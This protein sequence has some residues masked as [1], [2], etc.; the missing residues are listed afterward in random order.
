MATTPSVPGPS[1]ARGTRIR[2]PATLA[3]LAAWDVDR[4]KVFGR[5]VSQVMTS[6][7]YASARR[8]FWIVDDGSAHCGQP[9]AGGL[10]SRWPTLR[11]LH[12]ST[13]ASWLNQ[14]EI[15]FSV[16]Q[17][18]VL[19]SKHFHS[20]DELEARLT[21]FGTTTSR[22]PHHSN[23]SSPSPTLEDLLDCLIAHNNAQLTPAI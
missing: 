23:G 3:Y 12:L 17:R 5:L 20:V 7:P 21:N 10:Q 15:Y 1:G 8:V 2:S 22:S 4:A 13:D 14:V 18:K 19:A 16:A 6:A 9:A 11:L